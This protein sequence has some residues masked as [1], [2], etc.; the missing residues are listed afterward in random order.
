[1][2]SKNYLKNISVGQQINA[3][4]KSGQMKNNH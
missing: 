1:M 4:Q 3:M 2:I